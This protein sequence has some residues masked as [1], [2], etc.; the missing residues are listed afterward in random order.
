MF[1]LHI[2]L[3]SK[4]WRQQNQKETFY[5]VLYGEGYVYVKVIGQSWVSFLRCCALCFLETRSFHG[6]ELSN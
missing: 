6:L 4:N 3:L 2:T 5:S 1:S